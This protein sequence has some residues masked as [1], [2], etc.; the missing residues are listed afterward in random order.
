MPLLKYRTRFN[1]TVNGPLHIGHAYLCLINEF[2]AHNS[3]GEFSVRFEDNQPEWVWRFSRTETIRFMN[4]MIRDLTWLGIKVDHYYHQ[5]KMEEQLEKLWK[6]VAEDVW[7]DVACNTT[8]D[9]P[10]E[11]TNS[12][13]ILFP[14]APLLIAERV[15]YDNLT[16]TTLLIRGN[17]LQTTFCLYMYF[18]DIFGVARPRHVYVPQLSIA[19]E[20]GLLPAINKTS[21]NFQIKS[22]REAGMR[23]DELLY[24]LRQACLIHPNGDWSLSNIKRQPKW[25]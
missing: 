8:F 21:S 4:E 6:A 15:L 23:P 7:I 2:E 24:E 10:P 11:C 12:D 5:S 22:F 18:C 9:S 3:G 20:M 25:G 17:D 1:P 14:Y 13:F 19:G 16:F